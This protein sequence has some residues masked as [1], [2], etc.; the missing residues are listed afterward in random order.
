MCCSVECVCTGLCA[1]TKMWDGD[2]FFDL[3]QINRGIYPLSN[4]QYTMLSF[5]AWINAA[6]NRSALGPQA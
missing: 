2:R 5:A 6:R 3:I 4:N 1:S